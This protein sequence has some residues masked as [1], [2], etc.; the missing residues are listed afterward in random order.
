MAELSKICILIARAV[1]RMHAA[2]LAT[3]ICP[4]KIS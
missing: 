4:I 3:P 1:R 2:G